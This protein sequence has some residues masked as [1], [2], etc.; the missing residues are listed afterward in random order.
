MRQPRGWCGNR[1]TL[2][3]LAQ[4]SCLTL[5]P[6]QNEPPPGHHH[7]SIWWEVSTSRGRTARMAHR[8]VKKSKLLGQPDRLFR[9]SS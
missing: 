2:R 1:D 6:P 8:L 4:R 7:F 9:H 5:K 3:M